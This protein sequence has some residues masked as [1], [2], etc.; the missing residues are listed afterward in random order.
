MPTLYQFQRSGNCYKIRLMAA[1]LGVEHKTV[2]F[3]PPSGDHKKPEYLAINPLAQVPAWVEDDDGPICDSQAILVYLSRRYDDS[4]RWF[5]SDARAAAEVTRWLSFTAY[6]ILYGLA[7]TRA[8]VALGRP[9]DP[10]VNRPVGETA[11][12][13]LNRELSD[14]DWLAASAPTIADIA[15]YPY[16]S[17][18]SDGGFS[19]DGYPSVVA[20]CQRIEALDRFEP[21]NPTGDV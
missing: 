9:G 1:L 19:L 20:W 11:L 16:V 4:G 10:E 8:M 15:A 13:T 3:D 21:F 17:V 2:S 6:E 7:F 5:P 18:A 14:R 12:A